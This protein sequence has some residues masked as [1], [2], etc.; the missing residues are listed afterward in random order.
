ML[1]LK[2]CRLMPEQEFIPRQLR[3]LLIE[4]VRDTP[5]TLIHGPRQSGKTTFVKN[6]GESLDYSYYTFDDAETRIFA[7][8]DPMGFISD[9]PDQV[10]LDEIQRV[11]ELCRALKLSVDRNRKPGRFILTDSTS[12]L[13]VPELADALVGRM[14]VL[15]LHPL[16]Q[17]EIEQTQSPPFL[18]RL[19]AG[20]F[21]M[22]QKNRLAKSLADRIVSGGYPEALNRPVSRRRTVWFQ[23]YIHNIIQKDVLDLS[24]IRSLEAIPNL[25]KYAANLSGQLFNLS[26]LASKLQMNYNTV[27]DYAIL[28]QNLTL[29]FPER[30]I[31]WLKTSSF[32]LPPSRF[33]V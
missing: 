31:F 30:R 20:D 15:R 6:M 12:L 9:C 1:K 13:L 3:F 14:E 17:Q 5:V 29:F 22:R 7:Q 2:I 8:N 19:F 28:L 21:Q 4:S 16:S 33:S 24:K 26:T 32:S 18:D 25:L 27:R 10:I 11:P 23:N